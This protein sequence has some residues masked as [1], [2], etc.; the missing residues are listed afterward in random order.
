MNASHN[1]PASSPTAGR[2]KRFL[3]PVLMVLLILAGTVVWLMRP[4]RNTVVLDLSGTDGLKVAGT[5]VVDGVTREFAGVLPAQIAV[6]AR[7]FEYTIRM[8]EPKGQ[9]SA[10]L[11]TAGSLSTS[12]TAGG[13][14]SGVR[15]HYA[16]TWHGRNASATT[17]RKED[18]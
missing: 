7:T 2:R 17:V 5:L 8:R 6:E 11:T 14:F 1:H 16:S 10:K 13:D 18:K 15:G 3:V 12:V 4:A 9:L